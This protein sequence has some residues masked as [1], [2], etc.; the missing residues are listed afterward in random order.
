MKE[1][2]VADFLSGVGGDAMVNPFLVNIKG[3]TDVNVA[4]RFTMAIYNKLSYTNAINSNNRK[5]PMIVTQSEKGKNVGVEN[6]RKLKKTMGLD[7][8][9]DEIPISFLIN[10]VLNPFLVS[11][12]MVQMIASFMREAALISI[13]EIQ[14]KP[15]NHGFIS[16]GTIT[17]DGLILGDHLPVFTETIHQYHAIAKFKFL[18]SDA[19]E[20]VRSKQIE[21]K[22]LPKDERVPVIFGNP[23]KMELPFLINSNGRPIEMDCFAGLPSDTN[24]PFM[25][26][27]AIVEEVVRFTHFDMTQDEY[28]ENLQY[29]LFGDANGTYLSHIMTKRPDM[30]QVVELDNPPQG[31]DPRLIGD[32]I[33]IT[34]PALPGSPLELD[35]EMS[36]PLQ[37]DQYTFEYIG[38]NNKKLKS[39]LN[40]RGDQAKIWTDFKELNADHNHGDM[41]EDDTEIDDD[42][43]SLKE[44]DTNV[45][46][47]MK[48]SKS[49][50]GL[51]KKGYDAYAPVQPGD[52]VSIKGKS[53]FQAKV[54]LVMADQQVVGILTPD[55]DIIWGF[56]K[57]KDVVLVS[58][59]PFQIPFELTE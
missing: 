49:F 3:N 9:D 10:T 44:I 16:M 24:G 14:D 12:E 22:S 2:K 45:D 56:I 11:F 6:M 27:T 37:N 13:G 36:D 40:I 59:G 57:Y 58:P 8:S 32:G 43:S 50:Y 53:N 4:N 38:K 30:H 20:K 51:S 29:L 35:G 23:N 42:D 25:N 47:Y 5:V 18:D 31:V 7:T 15:H 33:L 17:D 39:T 21:L 28:P 46:E 1:K 41:E 48:K 26:A 54:D 52:I 19:I 34:I 55:E